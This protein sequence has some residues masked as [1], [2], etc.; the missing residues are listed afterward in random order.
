MPRVK[1]FNLPVDQVDFKSAVLQCD[2]LIKIPGLKWT[3]TLNPEI[4]LL[5]QKDSELQTAIQK[6]NLVTA[7]GMG[8]IWGLTYLA[9]QKPTANFFLKW[10]RVLG[11]GIRFFFSHSYRKKVFPERVAGV[12]LVKVLF[13]LAAKQGYR[14]FLLG[15]QKG[16]AETLKAKLEEKYPQ[17]KIVGATKGFDLKVNRDRLVIL[18]SDQELRV[19]HLIQK[20][21]PHL[22]LV[23]FGPPKQERWIFQNQS[24]LK[25]V[26]LAIGVGGTFDFLIGKAKRA[27]KFLQQIG[28][29]WLWRLVVEPKR[30]KR[31]VTTLPRFIKL[32][33]NQ[34][35]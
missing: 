31:M 34:K 16:V 22:L 8:L 25:G 30:F 11:S 33:A 27:P 12:D 35:H 18:N 28:L 10:M 15:G 14:I 19:K 29:E 9:T 23:A 1:L 2:R 6:A 24:A 7:D 13:A 3:V 32:V 20:T 4:L 21:N 26:K 5:A 17:I